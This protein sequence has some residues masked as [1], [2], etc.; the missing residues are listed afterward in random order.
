MR[1]GNSF[2]DVPLDHYAQLLLDEYDRHCDDLINNGTDEVIR[3]LWNQAHLKVL[4][5]CGLVA[6]GCH[7]H[8]PCGDC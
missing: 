3:Q 7:I 4:K 8:N 2:V 5:L 6:V 1:L